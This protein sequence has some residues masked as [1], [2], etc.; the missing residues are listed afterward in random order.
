MK[1]P[2]LLLIVFS[3]MAIGCADYSDSDFM[4]QNEVHTE[5]VKSTPINL[6]LPDL[7][8][9]YVNID[10]PYLYPGDDLTLWYNLRNFGPEGPEGNSVFDIATYLSSDDVLDGSDIELS[11]GYRACQYHLTAMWVKTMTDSIRIPLTGIPAGE[12]SFIIV[13]DAKPGLPPNYY[14]GV[15]E[16]REDNNAKTYATK[17]K[18]GKFYNIGDRGPAYGYIFYDKGYV[19]DNWR[20]MEVSSEFLPFSTKWGSNFYNV[21]GCEGTAI[22]T[23]LQNTIDSVMNDINQANKPTERCYNH[24]EISGGKVFDDW[25]LPSKDELHSI[26][27]NFNAAGMGYLINNGHFYWSSTEQSPNYAWAQRFSDGMLTYHPKNF[28]CLGLPVRAF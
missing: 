6:D 27:V 28:Y 11:G 18:I 8:V 25:F 13:V 9:Q 17:I 20:Y 10:N 2:V 26:Y 7:I 24:S 4:L 21:P 5:P 19:S 1:N 23:G 16:S 12:Y 14:P 22:G 3:L 15:E